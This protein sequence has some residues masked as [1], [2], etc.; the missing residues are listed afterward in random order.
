MH[1][2]TH[3]PWKR[4]L[5]NTAEIQCDSQVTLGGLKGYSTGNRMFRKYTPPAKGLSSGPMIV[6][7]RGDQRSLR[8]VGSQSRVRRIWCVPCQWKRSSSTGAAKQFVGLSSLK[9]V[10]SL[11]MR[12]KAMVFTTQELQPPSTTFH[13]V[14]LKHFMLVPGPGNRNGSHLS[15]AFALVLRSTDQG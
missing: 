13:F 12:L 1:R 11:L 7:A 8:T 14:S 10:S 3:V 9:S 4:K 6:P 5:H 2:R 15:R